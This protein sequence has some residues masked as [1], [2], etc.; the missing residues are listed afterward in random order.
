MSMLR[1][2]TLI[3][4]NMHCLKHIN[5][6]II[7]LYRDQKLLSLPLEQV[8][9]DPSKHVQTRRQLAKDPEMR[10]FAI[11]EELHQFDRLK[12]LELVDK[13]FGKIVINL[14]W[15]WKKKKDED[16][17]VIYNKVKMAF[18]N[19]PLKEEV[20][21]SQ[22]DGF[23]DPD[24]PK[25][26]YRLEKALYGLKQAPKAWYDELSTFLISKGFTKDLRCP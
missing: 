19:G 25:K 11:T 14:K 6:S 17:T 24:H 21:V 8:C 10:M 15:L 16:N 4:Q 2:T 23:V 18:L 13:P 3:K 7:L 20:Y 5:L 26:V 1:K 9:G 22:P 12:V